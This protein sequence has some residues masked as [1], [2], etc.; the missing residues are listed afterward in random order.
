M[1]IQLTEEH[2]GCVLEVVRKPQVVAEEGK[3]SLL[4]LYT[5]KK[6]LS[7]TYNL[8]YFPSFLL[9]FFLL[10]NNINYSKMVEP[11]VINFLFILKFL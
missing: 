9:N 2:V 1:K 8:F 6:N 5:E 7:I 11:I 3:S 4:N 10:N